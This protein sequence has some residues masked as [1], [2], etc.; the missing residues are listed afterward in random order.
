MDM[1][2]K[3]AV[4]IAASDDAVDAALADYINSYPDRRKL[5]VMFYRVEPG[6]YT[7]GTR[8]VGVKLELAKL[9]VR[10]GGGW[11]SIDEFLDQYTGEELERQKRHD[12]L[13]RL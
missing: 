10:V 8:K 11:I 3:L 1:K 5:K 9:K 4:Y 12:P 13:V 6:V 7:F 2:Q